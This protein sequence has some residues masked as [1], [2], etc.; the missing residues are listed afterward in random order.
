[1]QSPGETYSMVETCH[2]FR[3]IRVIE[4]NSRETKLKRGLTRFYLDRLDRPTMS[5]STS[6]KFFFNA[7]GQQ[8]SPEGIFLKA[9]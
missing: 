6:Q 5:G 1:M 9:K 4:T 2:S 8:E 3:E 7:M